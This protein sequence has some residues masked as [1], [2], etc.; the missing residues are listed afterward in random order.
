M[1]FPK[2]I[3]KPLHTMKVFRALLLGCFLSV[4]FVS[5]SQ[6]AKTPEAVVADTFK[7]LISRIEANRETYRA[8]PEALFNMVDEVLSPAIH[9]ES[10]ADKILGKHAKAASPEQKRQFAEEF[11]KTLIYTYGLLLLEY[12]GHE[13][14]I[15]PSHVVGED[16]VVVKTELMAGPESSIPINFYMS[17]RGEPVW[18]AR[19]LEGAGINFVTTYRST[20]SQN[21]ARN[22]LDSVIAELRAKNAALIR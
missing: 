19:N 16:R 15:N 1:Y 14:V 9:V 17:N 4:S 12:N 2:L 10:I 22:G 21:I 18:R 6:A 20:Y 8:D 3:A 11:K 13:L 7:I 5:V